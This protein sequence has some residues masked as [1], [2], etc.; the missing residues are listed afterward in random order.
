MRL[1]S[2]EAHVYNSVTKWKKPVFCW[3]VLLLQ[4]P[5]VYTTARF[6]DSPAAVHHGP[7]ERVCER[8]CTCTHTDPAGGS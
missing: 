3:E 4:A 2:T 8:V 6:N 7:L 1:R 5:T